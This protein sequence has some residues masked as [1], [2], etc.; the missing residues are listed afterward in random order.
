[1]LLLP[2]PVQMQ[3]LDRRCPEDWHIPGLLLME[4]AAGAALELLEKKYPN[5]LD[6]LPMVI[7]C[8][9]GNNGGDGLAMARLAHCRGYR[10]ILLLAAD[11]QQYKGDAAQQW[12]MV[13]G[14]D[15]PRYSPSQWQNSPPVSS[16]E[17]H[18][19]VDALFGTGLNRPPQGDFLLVMEW[20]NQSG[21]PVLALDIPSGVEGRLGKCY[22]EA[23]KARW[24]IALG[25][26][27][28]GN[29][30][31][32]GYAH[33]GELY[34]SPLSFPPE[35]LANCPHELKLEFPSCLDPVD[36]MAYKGSRGYGLV[37]GGSDSYRGAPFFAGRAAMAAGA[38]YVHMALPE[39][40][41]ENSRGYEE[42]VYH[43]VDSPWT[44]DHLK[45]LS[46]LS[47]DMHWVVLGPG[48]GDSPGLPAIYSDF[49]SALECPVLLDGDGLRYSLEQLAALKAPH[50]LTP[51]PG[52]A[53]RLLG[54]SVG[55]V[56]SDPLEAARHIAMESRG[57]V[58]LKQPHSLICSPEGEL[59]INPSGSSALATAG[60][61][62]ALSGVVAAMLGRGL[63]PGDACRSAAF[64]HGLAG[65]L[66]EKR[67]GA[68]G[69]TI[70]ELLAMVPETLTYYQANYEELKNNYNGR[71]RSIHGG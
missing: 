59:W 52:E 13:Q 45:K 7:C 2:S 8:G 40:L 44:T 38:G 42:L 41:R 32:P 54:L 25:L 63:E 46:E 60:S 22:P 56:L 17:P 55:E 15:I 48:L 43:F 16:H 50:I 28:P 53:A 33:Q 29:L 68:Q 9:P 6:S 62:D 39:T 4:Q 10:P 37:V 11:P 57:W 24:T 12:A 14:L 1:M 27:K 58:I 31:Y 49:L 35:L 19:W 61:G 69:G 66:L 65:E 3:A 30:L 70:Q 51:H 20:I 64:L 18:V 26:P 21:Q 5:E 23:L 34:L 36:P 71:L 47:Q 67:R